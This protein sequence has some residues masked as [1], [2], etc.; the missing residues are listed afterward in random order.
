MTATWDNIAWIFKYDG[1]L[2]DIYVQDI[3][4][5]DWR[6]LIDFLN[7][8]YKLKFGITGKEKDSKQ[9]D[10]DYMIRYLI[11]NS[12]EME[13]KSVTIDLEG[14]NI[15]C[16]FFLPDQIE[17][18]IDP[19]EIK[20]I[21]DYKKVEGFMISVSDTLKNQVTLTGDNEIKY[22][23]IKID[24][25]KGINKA[26]TNDEMKAIINRT[27]SLKNQIEVAMTG[28]IMKLFP[29]KFE[30]KVLKSANKPYKSTKKNN[31]VW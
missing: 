14:V 24:V 10:K 11:D 18:D 21:G 12:G 26:L 7:D 31:N 30:E 13:S 3:S 20:S 15:N 9:I 4:L 27:N 2:R 29:R 1:S 25:T 5:D 16:H 17:F 19:R 6:K 23:L 22:P 8:T 28:L